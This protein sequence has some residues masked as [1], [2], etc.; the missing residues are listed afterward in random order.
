MQE[1]EVVT[2]TFIRAVAAEVKGHDAKYEETLREWEQNNPKYTF[3]LHRNVS[4]AFLT[5]LAPVFDKLPSIAAMPSIVVLSSLS[6]PWSQNLTMKQ[7]DLPRTIYSILTCSLH[8]V[9]T[10]F[11]PQILLK[12]LKGKEYGK[13]SLA[14]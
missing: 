11:I 4:Q 12:N 7:V 2:D 9:I 8:R 1:E 10:P 5:P 3:L 14:D 6:N 13:S